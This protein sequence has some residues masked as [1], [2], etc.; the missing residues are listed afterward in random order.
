MCCWKVGTCEISL[1]MRSFNLCISVFWSATS[2]VMSSWVAFHVWSNPSST[3][4][5]VAFAGGFHS[6]SFSTVM[7]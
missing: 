6:M 3:I 5:S 2:E 7:P 4:E 1:S